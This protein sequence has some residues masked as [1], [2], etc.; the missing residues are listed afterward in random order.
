MLKQ[1]ILSTL[2]FFD[3]QDYPVTLLELHKFLLADI[4]TLKTQINT[5]WELIGEL[6]VDNQ[7]VGI[8]EMITCLDEECQN[9]V[10]HKNGFYC[11]SGRMENYQP[12][13]GKLYLRH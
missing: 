10:E 5:S 7:R 3:L 4:G 11:L 9:E 12:A 2:K 6:V 13:L 1:R 8:D